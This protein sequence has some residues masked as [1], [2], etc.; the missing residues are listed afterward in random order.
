[1]QYSLVLVPWIDLNICTAIHTNTRKQFIQQLRYNLYRNS[2]WNSWWVWTV[3]RYLGMMGFKPFPPKRIFQTSFS[4]RHLSELSNACITSSI[5]GIKSLHM[6]NKQEILGYKT[7]LSIYLRL[8]LRRMKTHAWKHS[9]KGNIVN[10]SLK[11]IGDSNKRQV[12]TVKCEILALFLNVSTKICSKYNIERNIRKKEWVNAK[13]ES[14]Q[15]SRTT[16]TFF[17]PSSS[18]PPEWIKSLWAFVV[19]CGFPRELTG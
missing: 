18:S 9:Y 15:G 10:K 17:L 3:L 8:L 12:D 4:T 7:I 19:V 14:Q 2:F 16:V 6:Q 1:M 5:L 11:D 13:K